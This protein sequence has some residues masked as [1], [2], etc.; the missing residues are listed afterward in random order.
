MLHCLVQRFI[1]A[2]TLGKSSYH[3]RETIRPSFRTFLELCRR[4]R[5]VHSGWIIFPHI[6][7]NSPLI[8]GFFRFYLVL[9]IIFRGFSLLSPFS[10]IF[11]SVFLY[12]LYFA[13]IKLLLSPRVISIPW[14]VR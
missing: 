2:D 3:T 4:R 9:V 13:S 5:R 1:F 11:L 6:P 10:S 8:S 14:F 12:K 7:P